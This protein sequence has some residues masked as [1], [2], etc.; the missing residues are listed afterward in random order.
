MIL[1]NKQNGISYHLLLCFLFLL[2]M[3]PWGSFQVNG[4]T[5]VFFMI[6]HSCFISK[7]VLNF[8]FRWVKR[9]FVKSDSVVYTSLRA[10]VVLSGKKMWSTC[11]SENF[12]HPSCEMLLVG[13]QASCWNEMVPMGGFHDSSCWGSDHSRV[14]NLFKSRGF[15]RWL[16]SNISYLTLSLRQCSLS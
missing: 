8:S 2:K 12:I 7:I 6:L 13:F 9:I 1:K 11:Q 3:Q 5:S 10:G 16:S 4:A 14:L 15:L